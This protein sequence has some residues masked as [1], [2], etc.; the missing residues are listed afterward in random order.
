[1]VVIVADPA[2]VAGGAAGRL[3]PA[4]QASSGERG[5]GLIH[6]LHRHV[7]DSLAYHPGDFLRA[8]MIPGPD[9]IEN[10]QPC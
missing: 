4:Q 3:D 2:L 9:G 1:V 6:G 7:A 8:R 5:Q 10:R